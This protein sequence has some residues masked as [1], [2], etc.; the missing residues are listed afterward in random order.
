MRLA[1]KLVIKVKSGFLPHL[2]NEI[3][4]RNCSA[5]N[6]SLSESEH[7][8]DLFIM[9]ILYSAYD[10]YAEIL[11]KIEKFEDSFKIVSSENIL[12]KGITG[13]LLNV[14]GKMRVENQ[15]DYEMNVLGAT[16]LSL[17]MIQLEEDGLKY[18]GISRNVALL[19]GVSDLS[20]LKGNPL[21]FYTLAERDSIIINKFAELNAFPVLINFHHG[22]D[23]IKVMQGIGSTYSAIRISVIENIDDISFYER[24]SDIMPVPVLSRF[25]DEIPMSLLA[26]ITH[27]SVRNN[28]DIKSC[29]A[30]VIGINISSLRLARLMRKLG[31]SRILG[32]DKNIQL[33]HSFEKEGGLATIE[34]NI[35]ENADLIIIFKDFNMDNLNGVGSGQ[36]IISMI[37]KKLDQEFLKDKG[38]RDILQ[39]N[40]IDSAAFF[41]GILKGLISSGKKYLNDDHIIKLSEMITGFK[42]K[43]EI[44]PGV[45]SSINEKLPGLILGLG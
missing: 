21:K 31:F 13:G 39:D 20:D 3:Y 16:E 32:S 44:L 24:I 5:R 26:A 27:V 28:I 7:G 1:T 36:M 18:S 41:P 34:E 12:E 35:F 11:K 22:D 43:D 23:F 4:K 10:E 37:E 45:F 2:I 33:M 40:W 14:S 19:C 8:T 17:K 15:I 42:G 25:Y 29:T 38:I 9:E 30:G 6:I